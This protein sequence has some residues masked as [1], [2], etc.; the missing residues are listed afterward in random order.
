M[1]LLNE[2]RVMVPVKSRYFLK[3]RIRQNIM[4]E[5]VCFTSETIIPL[6]I[7]TWVQEL[8]DGSGTR[9]LSPP[10]RPSLLDNAFI[11]FLF[12]VLTTLTTVGLEILITRGRKI[13]PGDI[14]MIP[15]NYELKLW[16]AFWAP[17]PKEPIRKQSLLYSEHPWLQLARGN[18]VATDSETR[19]M[20][21]SRSTLSGFYQYCFLPKCHRKI[22]QPK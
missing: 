21:T 13:S 8:R 10:P 20:L 1:K 22:Q 5:S 7:N 6:S 19:T 17:F 12:A 14:T 11:Q 3:S 2:D 9:F 4:G 15:V 18:C 16:R